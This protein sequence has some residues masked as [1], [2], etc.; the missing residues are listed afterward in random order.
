MVAIK[1][2][3]MTIFNSEEKDIIILITESIKRKKLKNIGR[4]M[5]ML[6]LLP[7][8]LPRGNSTFES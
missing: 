1:N 7:Y 6:I 3:K 5:K 4:V 8:F 2:P